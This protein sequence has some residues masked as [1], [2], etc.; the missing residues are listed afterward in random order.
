[1]IVPVQARL[2]LESGI[3]SISRNDRIAPALFG[4][5]FHRG[6]AMI[7]QNCERNGSTNGPTE[8][9]QWPPEKREDSADDAMRG[10]K[11]I[12]EGNQRRRREVQNTPPAGP[13]AKES[14]TNKEATPGSG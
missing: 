11:I 14:Q 7:D 10:P 4:Q 1:V 2:R 6:H 3:F 12:S 5:H 8:P 13:H 9:N